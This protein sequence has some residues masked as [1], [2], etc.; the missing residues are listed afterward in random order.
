MLRAAAVCRGL[1]RQQDSAHVTDYKLDKE[2]DLAGDQLQALRS[3]RGVMVTLN[4]F[5]RLQK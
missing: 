3:D 4:T 1:L 5:K 2:R